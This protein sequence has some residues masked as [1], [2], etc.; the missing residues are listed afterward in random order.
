MYISMVYSLYEML[1]IIEVLNNQLGF[2]LIEVLMLRTI[3]RMLLF[4]EGCRDWLERK[5]SCGVSK[6]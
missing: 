4:D 2:R 5:M 1:G 3:V 6:A